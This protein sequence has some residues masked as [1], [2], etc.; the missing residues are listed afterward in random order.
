VPGRGAPT[1]YGGPETSENARS[2]AKAEAM[3]EVM[4][5]MELIKSA[6][7]RNIM[8]AIVNQPIGST[9]LGWI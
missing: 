9:V 8:L 7:S 1:F 5:L 4:M 2:G 6:D 3:G